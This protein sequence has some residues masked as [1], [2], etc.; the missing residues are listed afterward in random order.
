[1]VVQRF[2][3]HYLMILKYSTW[4]GV[5]LKPPG[6]P[7]FSDWGFGLAQK[8]W[9]HLQ[10]I[11]GK[12]PSFCWTKNASWEVSRRR[13]CAF[14][15]VRIRGGRSKHGHI[16]WSIYQ[17]ALSMQVAVPMPFCCKFYHG[18]A[19]LTSVNLKHF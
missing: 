9:H 2:C 17:K 18:D 14:F 16:E 11:H 6:S 13:C 1:M 5:A 15:G 12:S 4:K 8:R 19:P 7:F 3:N 10:D